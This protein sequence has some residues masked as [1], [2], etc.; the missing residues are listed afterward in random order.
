MTEVAVTKKRSDNHT[1]KVEK[2][3]WDKKEGSKVMAVKE[4]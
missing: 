1:S 2:K 4:N 3:V